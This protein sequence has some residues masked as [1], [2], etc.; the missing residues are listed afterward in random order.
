MNVALYTKNVQ[1]ATFIP[2]EVIREWYV[3]LVIPAE[4]VTCD[5]AGRAE[6][7][8]VAF[9]RIDAVGRHNH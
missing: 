8:N 5:R 7:M 1:S 2:I 3:V 9:Y 4:A 6:S